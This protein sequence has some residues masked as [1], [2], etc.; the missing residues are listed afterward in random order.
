MIGTLAWRKNNNI[1]QRHVFEDKSGRRSLL[2][3]GVLFVGLLAIALVGIDFVNRL[4]ELPLPT[5]RDILADLI[6]S[7]ENNSSANPPA[8]HIIHLSTSTGVACEAD[9]APRQA[10]E[11]PVVA[12]IPAGDPTVTSA[13][14]RRCG[15]IDLVLAQS[16]TLDTVAGAVMALPQPVL[17]MLSGIDDAPHF[18]HVLGLRSP[19]VAETLAQLLDDPVRL[20]A[21]LFDIGTLVGQHPAAGICI[22]LSPVR[23]TDAV[24]LTRMMT[25][26]R[27]RL[28]IATC[29]IGPLD[30]S[31]WEDAG[32]VGAIDL[33]VAQA[34]SD[35][36][37]PTAAPAAPAWL[38]AHLAR[39]TEQV[40]GEKLVIALGTSAYIWQSGRA[41]P[42]IASFAEAMDRMSGATAGMAFL[43][44]L[45]TVR[46][47]LVDTSRQINDIWLQDGAVFYEQ[48][49]R[50]DPAQAVAI[51][52]LG[53]ED[54][55]VW[56]LFDPQLT[57]AAAMEVLERPVTLEDVV[58]LQGTGPLVTR[59][60]TAVSGLRELDWDRFT[61]GILAQSYRV[62]P[63]PQRIGLGGDTSP[64]GLQLTFDG[65]PEPDTA[66]ALLEALSDAR[67]RATF[68]VDVQ[69][70]LANDDVVGKVVEAKH[71]VGLRLAQNGLP[72]L[73]P[74]A[75]LSHNAGQLALMSAADVRSIFV[76]PATEISDQR[77]FDAY[78]RMIERGYLGVLPGKIA[79]NGYFDPVAFIDHIRE[80][81]T[82]RLSGIVGFELGPNTAAVVDLLPSILSGLMVEG[83]HFIPLGDV[84]GFGP[85]ELMPPV[86]HPLTWRDRFVLG[87]LDFYLIGL[88][89][90]FLVLMIFAAVRSLIYLVLAL[91]R[92]SRTGFDPDYCPPVTVIVPA[93]NEELV[94]VKC[95]ESLLAS[96]YPDLRVV[97]VDDGSTDRTY[98][99]VMAAVGGDDR[100]VLLHEINSGKWHAANLGLSVVSTP[101]FIIADADSLF[102]PDTI[103][104][105]VQQF[106]DE[107]VGAVAGLVEVGNREN[108]LT[109]CQTLEYIVSQSVMRRAYE[110]F[111]GILVVPGAVGAWRTEAVHA[112]RDFSGETITED[113]DLTIA[114]H[115]AGYRVRFQEQARAVTE[116]PDKVRAF[117]RQRLRWTFGMFEVSWKHRSAI[118]ERRA[119]GISIIDAIWFG[120]ISSLLS[121]V[122]DILLVLLIVKAIIGVAAGETITMTGLPVVVVVSYFL[123]TGLDILNTLV[124]FRFEKR[125]DWRLLALVPVL[126]FG[127]RQLLYVSTINAIWHALIGQIAGWNKLARTGAVFNRPRGMAGLQGGGNVMPVSEELTE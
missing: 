86:T 104:W 19:V 42:E 74:G 72:G 52:P 41:A 48:I 69:D 83:F 120:L 107:R 111:E 76:R 73:W 115:R 12:Y 40:P 110:V 31:F 30:A 78:V 125:F 94:I 51:W 8:S 127:Y 123:L 27:D 55:S 4:R 121:P 1:N 101:I 28:G 10:L 49:R 56:A 90:M 124:A 11:R 113:A 62:V 26:L 44:E 9:L 98:L 3:R 46:A 103:R 91:W 18:F 87:A 99:R 13:F 92:G 39:V 6:A 122:V 70:L 77:D 54:P 23:G 57:A 58:F 2:I 102:F 59:A 84:A 118:A 108:F 35:P 116:A 75:D 89:T 85:D 14:A 79:P 53:H 5:D 32:L 7:E 37:T 80:D 68:F 82:Q 95:I 117:L 119:V 36:A 126:R 22:D 65:L 81:T 114:V 64:L 106:K 88:T 34:F 61:G 29:V 67:I 109:S 63:R 60:E 50:L 96:D 105:L 97:V 38:E 21:I 20:E 43:P 33:A 45:G 25:A 15:A 24:V 112:A 17:P 100:V 71:D 16:M 66:D 93:F 47:R